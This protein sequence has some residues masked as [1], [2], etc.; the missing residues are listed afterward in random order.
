M[1]NRLTEEARQALVMAQQ[2]ARGLRYDSLDSGTLL[3]G[4]L[5]DHADAAIRALAQQGITF[6]AVRGSCSPAV[7]RATRPNARARCPTPPMRRRCSTRPSGTLI[8]SSTRACCAIWLRD[9]YRLDDHAIRIGSWARIGV[10]R[11]VFHRPAESG[12]VIARELAHLLR[13]DPARGAAAR[14]RE[15]SLILPAV[16]TFTPWIWGVAAAS[17]LLH[18]VVNNWTAELGS[19]HI[20]VTLHGPGQMAS[21]VK[22]TFTSTAWPSITHP[23]YAWR[24]WLARRSRGTVYGPRPDL[25]EP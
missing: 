14:W 8:G 23:P 7:R 18:R 24:L 16:L 19:D 3:L 9:D 2:A 1:L 10:S 5:T 4:L 15:R 25:L 13:K 11:E 17:I 20:A 22:R 6:E 12:Y 21:W